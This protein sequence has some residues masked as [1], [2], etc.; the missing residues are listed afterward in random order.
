[1]TTRI[2]H[3]RTRKAGY[4]GS[5]N[6]Q[7]FPPVIHTPAYR[8]QRLREVVKIFL[9]HL[10]V[11]GDGRQAEMVARAAVNALADTLGKES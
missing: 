9:A 3:A 5:M 7:D 4:R 6:E 8:R 1:M 10:A 2:K 11:W